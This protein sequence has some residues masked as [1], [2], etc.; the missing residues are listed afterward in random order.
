MNP[1]LHE[2]DIA[3]RCDVFARHWVRSGG[4]AAA[5]ARATGYS[6][7]SAKHQG[8]EL[9]KRP[10][11]QLAIKK[12]RAELEAETI[13]EV[14]GSRGDWERRLWE[15]FLLPAVATR[16]NLS[17]QLQAGR[18]LGEA[19]SWLTAQPG[20]SSTSS[21]DNKVF[22]IIKKARQAV[23]KVKA[24]KAIEAQPAQVTD[25]SGTPDLGSATGD[26]AGPVAPPA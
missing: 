25:G 5:A 10:E 22:E 13:A 18:M 12:Y 9:L 7:L 11:V 20:A 15:V 16:G 14:V 23:E 2:Y 3:E 21:L 26:S 17:N 4:N 6:V 1:S 8:A 24:A 19:N